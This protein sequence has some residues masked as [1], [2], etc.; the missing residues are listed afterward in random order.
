MTKWSKAAL[1]TIQ[2][3][4]IYNELTIIKHQS[5]MSLRITDTDMTPIPHFSKKGLYYYVYF[6]DQCFQLGLSGII[7][8]CHLVDLGASSLFR[9]KIRF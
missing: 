6:Q 4:K 7:H 1:I 2:M 9:E 8:K 5:I 3:A